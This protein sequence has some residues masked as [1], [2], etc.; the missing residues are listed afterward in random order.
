M[1]MLKRGEKIFINIKN[2]VKHVVKELS[3]VL[4]EENN[5][6]IKTNLENVSMEITDFFKTKLEGEATAVF[7]LKYYKY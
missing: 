7:L 1:K 6:F 5:Q 4:N 2:K 3:S